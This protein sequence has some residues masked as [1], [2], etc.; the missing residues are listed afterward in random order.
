MILP[1]NRYPLCGIMRLAMLRRRRWCNRSGALCKSLWRCGSL[2]SAGFRERHVRAIRIRTSVAGRR[3]LGSRPDERDLRRGVDVALTARRHR[4]PACT[5]L[6]RAT[7][8]A[9][10]LTDRTAR[11]GIVA[12]A[13]R[14]INDAHAEAVE[15]VA[16][17]PR[18]PASWI[19]AGGGAR[20]PNFDADVGRAACTGGCRVRAR[21]RL[22]DR[23]AG[24][25][26]FRLSRGAQPARPPHTFPSTTSAPRPLTGGVL[27]KP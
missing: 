17:L 23:L 13:E 20:Q 19:V 6:R 26:G 7:A 10:N 8:A 15:I 18:P 21:R 2:K 4:L 24:G 11:P 9:A 5:L 16:Q 22:V 1:E 25:A 14:L 12:E 27:A 3:G